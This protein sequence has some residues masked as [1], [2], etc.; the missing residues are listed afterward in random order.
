RAEHLVV[1]VD[2]SVAEDLVVLVPVALAPGVGEVRLRVDDLL[3]VGARRAADGPARVA[4][5][6]ALAD[7]R[8]TALDA[9]AIGG[10]DED[11]VRMRGRHAQNVR[12]GLALLVLPRNRYPV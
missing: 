2:A 12:H 6:H 5:D 9:D 7:E 10:G 4:H 1:D 8:L 3:A 11:G